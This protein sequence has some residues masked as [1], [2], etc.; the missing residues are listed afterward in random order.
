MI[1]F[2]ISRVSAAIT[3]GESDEEIIAAGI[4]DQYKSLSWAFIT[5]EKWLKTF[6]D[7]ASAIKKLEEYDVPCAP[8]LTVAETIDHPHLVERGT[9][10]SVVDPIAGEFKIPG[11]PIKTS[12]YEANQDYTAPCLGEHNAD[13][14]SS[15]LSKTPEEIVE[16]VEAGILQSGA[17]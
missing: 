9:V 11:M 1:E 7:V 14:L 12:E 6:P 13:I 15:L 8:V 2:S 17:T 5:E 16:M 4:G 10:R 3:K